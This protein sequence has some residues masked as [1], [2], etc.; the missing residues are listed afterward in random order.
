MLFSKNKKVAE[1]LIFNQNG[2]LST[3]AEIFV[4]NPVRN[5]DKLKIGPI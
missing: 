2:F 5:Q 3:N 1:P 4:I